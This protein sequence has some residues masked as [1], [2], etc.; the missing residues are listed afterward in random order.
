MMFRCGLCNKTKMGKYN[1]LQY[2]ALNDDGLSQDYSMKI[3]KPC[4]VAVA[5]SG[6]VDKTQFAKKDKGQGTSRGD[7]RTSD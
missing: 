3:C 7:G 6:K 4:S 5:G 2:V 1:L